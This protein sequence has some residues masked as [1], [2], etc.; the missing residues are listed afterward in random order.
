MISINIYLEYLT[1]AH[2]NNL[3]LETFTNCT[4]SGQQSLSS[5]KLTIYST[6][7][8]C[9]NQFSQ[10]WGLDFHLYDSQESL[11]FPIIDDKSLNSTTFDRELYTLVTVKNVWLGLQLTINLWF[12]LLLTEN[13]WICSCQEFWTYSSHQLVNNGLESLNSCS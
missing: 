1:F 8:F 4:I 12:T 3:Q 13:I 10:Y 7:I 2:V 11:T 9:L 6:D 5:S